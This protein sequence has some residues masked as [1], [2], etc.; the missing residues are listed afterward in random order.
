MLLSFSLYQ[1]KDS[2]VQEDVTHIFCAP[3][4]LVMLKIDVSE[5]RTLRIR[6]TSACGTRLLTRLPFLCSVSAL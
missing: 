1:I 5:S 6:A 4:A 3:D 2:A